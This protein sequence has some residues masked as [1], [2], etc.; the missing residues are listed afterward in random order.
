MSTVEAVLTLIAKTP[1]CL[2]AKRQEAIAI[3]VGYQL[4]DDLKFYLEN[5][6]SILFYENSEYPIKI[7]GINDFKRA[8]P[9]IIGEDI[10]D[11]ISYN[12]FVIATGNNSQYITIDLAEERLGKCHDSFWDRY[13]VAG[14]QPIIANSFTELLQ[15]VYKNEG[16]YY[17]WLEDTFQPIGDAYDV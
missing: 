4:P 11:D 8:S 5:Y 7:V 3:Q 12:W 1:D 13:G 16:G 17:Y 9:I 10:K 6:D 14:E 15:A 2:V